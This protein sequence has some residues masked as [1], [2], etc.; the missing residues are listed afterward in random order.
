M[1]RCSRCNAELSAWEVRKA[2]ELGVRPCWCDGLPPGTPRTLANIAYAEL[3]HAGLTQPV[4]THDIVRFLSHKNSRTSMGSINVALSEDK[5]FCWGGRALYGLARHG[6]FP[7]VRSLAEAAY[8]TLLAAPRELHVEEV[9]FVLEQLN[10]RF[11]SDSLAHHLRGYT[12]NRWNLIF[13]TDRWNRVRVNTG[14]DARH[15]YNANV[16]VCPTQP[17]F[18]AWVEDDLAPKVERTLDDRARRLADLNGR[19]IEIA[20]DRIDFQ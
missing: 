1:T 12:S 7:G 9:D 14:R 5:R 19:K 3:C 6:P 20:R 18:D 2:E 11:N 4:K 16:R 10:Y 15:Q 17:A 8:A 13:Q